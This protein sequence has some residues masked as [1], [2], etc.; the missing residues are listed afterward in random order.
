MIIT[1]SNDN[2]DMQLSKGHLPE[3]QLLVKLNLLS[4]AK[5][6][7]HLLLF[8][9]PFYFIYRVSFSIVLFYFC[10]VKPN[11]LTVC[12]FNEDPL[13]RMEMLAS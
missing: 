12:V 3:L 11:K 9:L 6:N 2:N 4:Y 8:S 5:L 7:I 1:M 10:Y 13:I